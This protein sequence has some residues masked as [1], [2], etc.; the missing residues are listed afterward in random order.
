MDFEL[1]IIIPKEEIEIVE[2]YEKKHEW[3]DE[4]FS[5]NPPRYNI[6]TGLD[7]EQTDLSYFEKY[8]D[9]IAAS[10]C[11]ALHL[12]GDILRDLGYSVNHS[13]DI[14]NDTLIVFLSRLL[15]LSMF[16]IFLVR[17]DEKVKEKYKVS[18]KEEIAMIIS[19]C[20]NWDNPYD[21][22]IYK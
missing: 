9:N 8:L 20:L 14:M 6:D 16:Y 19:K 21:V 11:I 1:D 17:E 13:I 18:D 4:T 2:L 15:E 7:F 22:L 12:K 10:E 5:C 3:G